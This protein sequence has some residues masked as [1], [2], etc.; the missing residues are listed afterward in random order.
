MA[1]EV[2]FKPKE[3]FEK[4]LRRAYHEAAG[5]LYDELRGKANI[6]EAANKAHVADY[7]KKQSHYQMKANELSSTKTKRTVCLV[8][9]ILAFI[10][11]AIA[12]VLAFFPSFNWVALLVGIALLGLGIGLIFPIRRFGKLSLEQSA[13]VVK[14]KAEADK[15]LDV[16]KS[17]MAPLNALFDWNAPLHVMEKATPIIDLDPVFTPERLSLLRDNYGLNEGLGDDSS[18][19]GVISGRIK[20]NPFVLVRTLDRAIIDKT[21]VGSMVI[22]WTT[23]SRDS[24]GRSYPVTHTQTLTAS[25]VHPAPKFGKVT[26]LIYGNAAAPHL[27]FSRSPQKSSGL[28]E[29]ARRKEC[30]KM[31]KKL[32][33]MAEKSIG[34]SKPFTPLANEEFETLFHALDRDHDVE[35]R[36]L[37]TPL[38]QQNMIELLTDP[39]PYGDDFY[40]LKSHKINVI[41]SAHSQS[42]DY[43]A[44]PSLFM[45]YDCVA[46]RKGFI[47]YCD[48]YIQSLFF[49]LAPLLSIP[50]Y[51]MHK[52]RDYIYKGNYGRNVTSFEQEALA[53][54]LDSASFMPKLADPSVPLI[55]KVDEVAKQGKTDLTSVRASGYRTFAMVDYVPTMGGDGRMHNVPVPWTRY[56]EVTSETPMQVRHVCPDKGTFLESLR[57]NQGLQ[58]FLSSLRYRY[59]RGLLARVGEGVSPSQEK[60]LADLFDAKAKK[61]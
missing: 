43:S 40:F 23:Y 22:S 61:Q 51:Q 45:G 47:D 57:K 59:E 52:S 41:Q 35:F 14:L 7:N 36:V 42:F 50:L 26:Q 54:G 8:F 33:K 38:A 34:T 15:A 9:C 24:N 58:N 46:M 1:E 37:F 53:N 21:Y 12:M 17:D 19:L 6:D 10:A 32:G 56:E 3:L 29:D 16:C 31:A 2:L 55:L 49:D 28:D 13:K 20:G 18:V 60:A 39:R 44:D 11:G 27:S 5:E 25:T 30:D 4:E 48:L